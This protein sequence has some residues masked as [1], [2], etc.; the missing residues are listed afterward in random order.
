M[1]INIAHVVIHRHLCDW[2]VSVSVPCCNPKLL[3]PQLLAGQ[4]LW[5]HA[6]PVALNLVQFIFNNV[7]SWDANATPR[8]TDSSTVSPLYTTAVA[9]FRE[10][11]ADG[12]V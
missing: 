9:S 6:E 4:G 11:N 12:C 10:H 8:W 7:A 3:E 1:D 2:R 5:I